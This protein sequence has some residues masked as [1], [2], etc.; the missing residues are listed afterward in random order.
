MSAADLAQVIDALERRY[1]PTY[2]ESWDAVGLVL[3]DPAQTVRK[4]L[5]AVDHGIHR[6]DGEQHLAHG[7]RGIAEHQPDRIPRLG[8]RRR[9]SALEG[10][11]HLGE[12]CRAD[13]LRDRARPRCAAHAP[14]LPPGPRTPTDQPGSSGVRMPRRSGCPTASPARARR[15]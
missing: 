13:R 15:E 5:F 9:I 7:L 11:D 4:V 3:G 1:P 14:R 6:V 2:A 10:V 8:V 12:T